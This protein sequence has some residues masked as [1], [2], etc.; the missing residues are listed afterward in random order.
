M[1]FYWCTFKVHWCLYFQGSFKQDLYYL[2]VLS[3]DI[4][5]GWINYSLFNNKH[6]LSST[7]SFNNV[8]IT[9]E[10][11]MS[12]TPSLTCGFCRIFPLLWMQVDCF[13]SLLRSLVT[14]FNFFWFSDNCFLSK[15]NLLSRIFSQHSL[16]ANI[17]S[18][19]QIFIKKTFIL[20]HMIA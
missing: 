4:Q 19:K 10:L 14:G 6:W 2:R 11:M 13:T 1:F 20:S 8:G 3:S 5:P 16:I 15:L 17:F 7:K 18:S 9:K 12:R